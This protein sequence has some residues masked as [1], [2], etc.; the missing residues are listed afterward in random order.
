MARPPGSRFNDIPI[1]TIPGVDT[2]GD[3]NW[4]LQAHDKGQFAMSA[5]MVDTMMR[6]DRISGVTGARLGAA[7]ASPIELKPANSKS[8]AARVLKDFQGDSEDEVGL[9][10]KICPPAVMRGLMKWGMHLGFGLAQILWITNA[11]TW[12]PRLKLWHPQFVFWHTGEMR[13][14]VICREGAFPLPRV[15]EQAYGDA[16]WFVWTPYGYQYGWLDA[17]VRSL[18]DK[19]LMRRWTYRDWARFNERHGMP[20]IG[21]KVPTELGDVAAKAKLLRDVSNIGSEAVVELPS[22]DAENQT[23]MEMIEPKSRSFESFQLFKKEL[24][25]DI[26]IN[27]NGQNLTTEGGTDGGS[28]ALGQVQNQV[29]GDIRAFDGL[30]VHAIR[31][32]VLCPWAQ[33]NYG[34]PELAPRVNLQTEPPEDEAVKATTW[35]T[36]GD[37]IGSLKMAGAPV[38]VRQMLERQ[39]IPMLSEAEA[40]AQ[41]AV[42]AE[43]AAARMQ[44]AAKANDNG[45]GNDNADAPAGDKKDVGEALSVIT[46]R[47]PIPGPRKR[48]QFQDLPI[49]VENE[50]GSLRVWTSDGPNG[51]VIGS[52]KMLFDYGYI[53]GHLSNDDEELDCYVGPDPEAPQVYVVHQSLAPDF[54]KHDEDKVFLGFPSTDAAR[55]AYVAHRNDGDRA[56]LGMSSIPLAVFKK[57]LKTRTGTGKI[58]AT[59]L[60]SPEERESL[61]AQTV[62][63]LMRL[64]HSGAPRKVELRAGRRPRETY[65]DGLVA[66]ARY[67][68][69]RALAV[70]LKGMKEEIDRLDAGPDW[71][72]RLKAR[73]IERYRGSKKPTELAAIVEK[74]R[75][76]AHA[77]GWQTGLEDV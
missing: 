38:D 14:Y 67:L 63:S 35:K 75:I 76:M 13:Y 6:D 70:D 52:T 11:N 56:I 62:E 42:E 72:E 33:F 29:R 69:A 9:W 34:D 4:I 58:R 45:A 7:L 16:E 21:M 12:I 77:A 39:G 17:L 10:R 55:A 31:E 44:A 25:V 64:V 20:I 15:D 32:Q 61:R 28:R 50:A 40:A 23:E 59:A 8:K 30:L 53:E 49:A 2:V 73:I 5:Q 71:P 3:V 22:I 57:R 24:D 60:I 46:K 74:A 26:A 54:Q 66:N 36:T 43:E 48:Y 19:Y 1:Q 65:T 51:K 41:R 37:A 68:A 18:A 47:I 27:V